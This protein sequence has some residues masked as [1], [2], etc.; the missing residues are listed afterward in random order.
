MA[1]QMMLANTYIG[2]VEAFLYAFKAGINL[3]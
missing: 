1:N 2:M 3:E